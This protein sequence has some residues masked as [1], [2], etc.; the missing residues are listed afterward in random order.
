MACSKVCLT[1][2]PALLVMVLADDQTGKCTL[3]VQGSDGQENYD[4]SILSKTSGDFFTDNWVAEENARLEGQFR[5]NYDYYINVCND[6]VGVRD[7]VFKNKVK[8]GS[9][10]LQV[11]QTDD[12]KAREDSLKSG[13]TYVKAELRSIHKA[14][15]R[16]VMEDGDPSTTCNNSG[17]SENCPGRTTTILMFCADVGYGAPIFAEE[18]SHLNYFFVWHTCAACELSDPIRQQ[19]GPKP[20]DSCGLINIDTGGLSTGAVLSITFFVL[21][22]FYLV[23]GVL[24]N[25]YVVGKTGWEQM[26]NFEFWSSCFGYAGSGCKYVFSGGRSSGTMPVYHIQAGGLEIDDDD[27]DLDEDAEDQLYT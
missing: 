3:T 5:S 26:P 19:C 12:P 20:I 23:V 4:I 7:S 24:Y 16:Y 14:D 10:M 13:G 25:R 17:S 8:A 9:S 21:F 6:L 2:L 15:L 1:L 22:G 11:E 27:S 18:V